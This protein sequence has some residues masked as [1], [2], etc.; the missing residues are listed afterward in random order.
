[1]SDRPHLPERAPGTTE[2]S[3]SR[4]HQTLPPE[5]QEALDTLYEFGFDD[6]ADR[7]KYDR[8]RSVGAWRQHHEMARA[9]LRAHL[10]AQ[11]GKL[12]WFENYAEG[13]DRR[14]E[15][16]RSCLH[17]GSEEWDDLDAI[18]A[19]RDRYKE[20]RDWL[21]SQLVTA[22][23]RWPHLVNAHALPSRAEDIWINA[24]E[25]AVRDE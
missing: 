24:A 4:T 13:R 16:I 1:M 23:V 5:V 14:W 18:V 15:R 10:I 3:T 7:A 19:E 8:R 22:K 11:A 6:K 9:T 17:P 25:E 2:S 12:E 20:E 21:A